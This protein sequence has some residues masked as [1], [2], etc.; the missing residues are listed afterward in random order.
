M[1]PAVCVSGWVVGWGGVGVMDVGEKCLSSV[2]SVVCC[3]WGPDP[4]AS[5][6]GHIC[7]SRDVFVGKW[8][9]SARWSNLVTSL[10]WLETNVYVNLSPLPTL[11]APLPAPLH[12]SAL[13]PLYSS[14]LL[15]PC[16]A[17][18]H[19]TQVC[20]CATSSGHIQYI[21]SKKASARSLLCFC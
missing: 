4:N 18:K 11:P 14:T 1:L 15:H 17:H 7:C 3:G 12:P 19:P 21:K 10:R 5:N 8:L 9:N 6:A 20:A 2:A 13:H 16:L